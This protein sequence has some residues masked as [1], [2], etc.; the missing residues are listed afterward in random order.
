M[1]NKITNTIIE[2]G[3]NQLWVTL[4]FHQT[5]LRALSHKRKKLVDIS[6][7]LE[8]KMVDDKLLRYPL[9]IVGCGLLG[10][11]L[12]CLAEVLYYKY[13]HHRVEKSNEVT[14]CQE[15]FLDP[16]FEVINLTERR[17][18]QQYHYCR[19]MKIVALGCLFV[20]KQHT[21]MSS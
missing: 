4:D 11:A 21:Y 20:K 1:L 13:L 17:R 5:T 10:S 6:E 3:L 19:K 8:G 9:L 14:E 15:D 7:D 2:G 18:L 12:A 16:Q